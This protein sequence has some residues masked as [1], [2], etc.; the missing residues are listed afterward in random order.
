MKTVVKI[1][2]H[3]IREQP[4]VVE[5]G[6]TPKHSPSHMAKTIKAW[7]TESRERRNDKANFPLWLQEARNGMRMKGALTSSFQ[8]E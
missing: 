4:V 5:E 3:G 1:V 2:K 7:I 6:K 8:M